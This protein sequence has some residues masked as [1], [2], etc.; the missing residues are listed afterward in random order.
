MRVRAPGRLV[1]ALVASLVWVVASLPTTARPASPSSREVIATGVLRPLQLAFDAGTLVVL[2][3]GASGD[4]A[5]Q[6]HRVDLSGELPVDL[7]RQPSIRIPFAN[8]RMA[9]LGSL[10]IDPSSRDMFLGEENGRA[11]YR[12]TRDERLTLYATG[13][14]RLPGGS[15]VALDSIGR[16]V[17]LDYA[18]PTLSSEHERMPPGLEELRAEDYRGPLVLRLTL[19]P[20]LPLPRR[21]GQAPP[22]FPRVWGGKAGGGLLPRLIAVTPVATGD[23]ALLSS[24]GA[25]YRLTPEGALSLIARLPQGFYNRINMVAGPDGS[26]LVSGGFHVPRIFQVSPE[27]AVSVLADEL[28][29]PEGIALDD[30]GRLYVAESSLHRVIRLRPFQHRGS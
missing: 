18:D 9:S 14:Q 22:V 24:S 16:L 19:D 11:I 29:D 2:S 7:S 4:S 17:I 6:I 13:L 28:G 15:T 3:P 5:A 21:L 25:L 10:A 30:Q 8:A 27:G 1:A 26:V 12:L 20:T 23:L